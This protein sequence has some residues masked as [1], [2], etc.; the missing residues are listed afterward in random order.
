M[1]E[2]GC[3]N[4]RYCKCYRSNSYWDPDEYECVGFERDLDI[5]LTQDQYDEIAERCWTNDERWADDEEPICPA[6]EYRPPE[7]PADE[8]WAKYAYEERF[9]KKEEWD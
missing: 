6:Y 3:A 1:K 4:C 2:N 9:C 8:Y 5:E 7:D